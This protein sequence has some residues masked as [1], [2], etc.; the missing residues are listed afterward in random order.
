M[1]PILFNADVEHFM[2]KLK[3]T[4]RSRKYGIT[5][6]RYADDILLIAS[7]LPQIKRMLTD[8][9]QEAEKVGLKLHPGKTKIPNNNTGYGIG[10]KEA[11]CGDITVQI[12]SR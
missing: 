11:R 1:S 4:L 8:L 12:L 9:N 2:V 10:A 5:N 3:A 7:S 6:L